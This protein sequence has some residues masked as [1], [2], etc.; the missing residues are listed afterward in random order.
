MGGLA[1]PTAD[2]GSWRPVRLDCRRLLAHLAL[3]RG[4][5]LERTSL[6]YRLW[7]DVSEVVA[8]DR[9]R[10]MLHELRAELR[11]RGLGEALRFHAD[12]QLL[13]LEDGGALRVDAATFQHACDDLQL[14]S[15]AGAEVLGMLE[16][17]LAL[18]AQPLLPELTA[19]D[20]W[21]A[22]QAERLA[23]GYLTAMALLRDR[24]AAA[25]DLPAAL[26][27]AE[28]VTAAAP[29]SERGAGEHM[30]LLHSA[31]R[32]MEALAAFDRCAVA[33]ARE[34]GERP[35]PWLLALRDAVDRGA[36]P[37]E[38]DRLLPR[39]D[40]APQTRPQGLPRPLSSFH[41][42]V[43][44]LAWL[45]EAL[46]VGR[47]AAILGPGG[48]GKT[49]LAVEAAWLMAGH[50]PD[51]IWFLP[52]EEI[53]I[54]EGVAVFL[55][56]LLGLQ[57][58][59]SST[60]MDQLRQAIGHKRGLL[61]LDNCEHVAAGARDL[62]R[63][64][65]QGCPHLS[66]VATSRVALGVEEG[67]DLILGPL[68]VPRGE[69]QMTAD[70]LAGHA[71]LSLFLDRMRS[72]GQEQDLT[73]AEMRTASRI[74]RGVEGV[75][76]AVELA[77]ARTVILPLEAIESGLRAK[78]FSLLRA[79]SNDLPERH[80]A[81]WATI[82]WSY[83][84]LGEDDRL[85]LQRLAVFPRDI[86]V[87][88]A[89]AVAGDLV[90]KAGR[91]DATVD[92]LTKAMAE[93]I[94]RLAAS[95][96]LNVGGPLAGE[97]AGGEESDHDGAPSA[98]EA[99]PAALIEMAMAELE[100][101]GLYDRSQSSAE[102]GAVEGATGTLPDGSRQESP[103]ESTET[104]TSAP[105]S[106]TPPQQEQRFWMY[107]SVREF[108]LQ[109]LCDTGQRVAVTERC[110]DHYVSIAAEAED[111][112]TG[113]AQAYWLL[114][115]HAE[116]GN[117]RGVMD[118]LSE[119]RDWERSLIIGL[120]L[121]RFWY[122]TDRLNFE[123]R[124]MEQLLTEGFM[125]KGDDRLD[126]VK[127]RHGFAIM[128]YGVGKLT[129]A[130]SVLETCYEA[131]RKLREHRLANLASYH[132]A[133][134]LQVSLGL[135]ESW[136][137]L[138]A[139]QENYARLGDYRRRADVLGLMGSI[140]HRSCGGYHA[141]RLYS[142]GLQLLPTPRSHVVSSLA[143]I[144][145]IAFSCVVT[146]RIQVAERL[147]QI[148][149]DLTRAGRLH[150][151][152]IGSLLTL[153]LAYRYSDRSDESLAA[154]RTAWIRSTR[155]HSAD[156]Q[157]VVCYHIGI[158]HLDQGDRERARLF[159]FRSQDIA[160]ILG[161]MQDYWLAVCALLECGELGSP[162]A[163][164]QHLVQQLELH[165]TSWGVNLELE[166]RAKRAIAWSRLL[167]ID[168][169]LA[170]G[171]LDTALDAADSFAGLMMLHETGR[172]LELIGK[173]VDTSIDPIAKAHFVDID[174]LLSALV[175]RRDKTTAVTSLHE[176]MAQSA[177]IPM[178]I[179]RLIAEIAG[180]VARDR[181]CEVQDVDLGVR[182]RRLRETIGVSDTFN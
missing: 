75:P 42:R 128:L 26:R 164:E 130:T 127:A 102:G 46:G 23:D 98:V 137:I 47:M 55:A 132:Q 53:T 56:Q 41:G 19:D 89:V 180:R 125:D 165:R 166:A 159:L 110:I 152:E 146:G 40:N 29:L 80:Q 12:R 100:A 142:A 162:T 22:Q 84:L 8:V 171:A 149:I 50:F 139:C 105:V 67:R 17:P 33:I 161:K 163:T 94:E 28:R 45:D 48:M 134:A 99:D 79:P 49:R 21:L 92:D 65:L 1:L 177:D 103:S 107:V 39:P 93:R 36:T 52:L 182:L 85:L 69:E 13:G 64:L 87:S 108:A 51:G 141:I 44:Q 104:S 4:K 38:V 156:H 133:I 77:A 150:V 114:R 129:D 2:G 143:L 147:S 7:P 181:T 175:N 71:A 66:I 158:A 86:T 168:R 81:L 58:Q 120:G 82:D 91:E 160:R 174:S 57:A 176:S 83:Q 140:A 106:P 178:D 35:A 179:N 117:L 116:H 31:G 63:D 10:R 115:L 76:L 95:S 6:A 145:G 124:W 27:C 96:L 109:H 151:W 154:L 16:R 62:A 148:A 135:L 118:W 59:S 5:R 61:V 153:A 136:T 24:L 88:G 167:T 170:L 32:R 54:D 11:A 3:E 25:D 37:R 72:M 155:T 20:D 111:G 78:R 138:S 68:P 34:Q 14:L 172:T 119:Q 123:L 73:L 113:P 169:Q 70:E 30:R 101:A 15:D 112:F 74:C 122:Q 18:G 144:D 60:P 9:L 43:E 173:L 126:V 131:Y 157:A 90:S 121:N 97:G